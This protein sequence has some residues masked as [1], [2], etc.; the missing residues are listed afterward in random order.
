MRTACED[1]DKEQEEVLLI[2][3]TDA[4]VHPRTVVVHAGDAA[5]AGRAVVALRDL[6]GVAL[7]AA[8]GKD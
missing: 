6:D 2:V 1:V 7:F 5:L 4:V 8:T 3:V